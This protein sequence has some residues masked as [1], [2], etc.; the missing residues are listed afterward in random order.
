MGF[1]LP[2]REAGARRGGIVAGS[3]MQVR[4]GV[5]AECRSRPVWHVWSWIVEIWHGKIFRCMVVF[6]LFC[7]QL[8]LLCLVLDIDIHRIGNNMANYTAQLNDIH[9]KD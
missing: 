8:L 2:V 3:E 6:E 5:P 4:R 1:V 7:L 9:F